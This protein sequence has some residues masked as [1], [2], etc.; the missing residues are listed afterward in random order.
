MSDRSLKLEVIL[1][2]I[3]KATGPIKAV[4]AGSKGLSSAVKEAKDRL[5]ELEQQN[6]RLENFRQV[7]RDVAVTGNAMAAAQGKVKELAQQIRATDQPSKA[8][9]R[10]FEVAKREAAQ[11]KDRHQALTQQQQRLRTELQAA[12]V[13]LQGMARHQA[14]LRRKIDE[15]AGAVN[16]QTEALKRQGEQMRRLQSA[17]EAYDKT[18]DTRNKLAGAGAG[19]AATGAAIGAPIANAVREYSSFEDAMLGVQRQVQGVGEI[20]SASYRQIVAEVKA[21]ARELPVP[22]NQIADMYTAAARMEVPRE[23]LADFTRTVTQMATAFDAVPDE[24]A[25]AMGKVAKNFKI[26]VTEIR[27]LADTINYL[28]DNAIS[29]A[30]DIIDVLN[31]TSGVAASVKISEKAVAALAS[32]LLTLGDTRETAGTAINAIIQRFAAAESGTKDFR[33]AMKSVGLSLKGVQTGMQTDAQGA[34]FQVID[35]IK[36][37]PADQRIGIMVDLVG[38]EHSDTMAKLV[39]NTEEWRRQIEL[40]NDAAASGSMEREFQKRTQAMSAHWQ[41]FKN[42][43]FDINTSTG[44]AL[45][46]RLLGIMDAAGGVLTRIAD[47]MQANPSLTAT[48]VTATAAV[49]A[50]V[51]GMGA[52]T[53]AMAAVLGPFAMA[54]YGIAAFGVFASKAIPFVTMLGKVALP[55]VG[56]A[57]LWIGR[58]L[59]ANPIGLAVTGIALAAGLVYQH[60][61]PIKAWFASIWDNVKQTT[62]Q[63]LE[64]FRGLPAQ[65]AQFGADMM[66][67]LADGIRNAGAAVKDAVTGAAASATGWFKDK[68]GIRSPSRVFAELGGFTMQGLAQGLSKNG[69]DAVDAVLRTARQITLASAGALS[70]SAPAAADTPAAPILPAAEQLMR[71]Q[72]EALPD[73]PALPRLAQGI[74]YQVEQAPAMPELPPALQQIR[75]QLADTPAAPILPAA[76]RLMRYQPEGAMPSLDRDGGVPIDTRQPLAAPG[77]AQAAAPA[78]PA[79]INITINAAPGMDP[80]AIARAVAAEIER[81]QRAQAARGRTRLADLE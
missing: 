22:T 59:M 50:I 18:M 41:R 44:G 81:Q 24:I 31:R 56:Q 27:G 8:M 7:A 29:K 64:F 52:L 43:L 20:G 71:Y 11:L 19:M 16:R 25:E 75:Y 21:L 65:F 6:K 60:W 36:D 48:I 30:G 42:L 74:G 58:A 14:E 62:G 2:A 37:L 17:R 67:G 72:A 79:N 38:M 73:V 78:A 12:G 3:D 13:P 15:A 69:G 63:A 51:T 23:A 26:P 66:R 47:W 45:R 55:A 35:A 32:T 33:A 61:E 34:L 10:N 28:D 1:A 39:S 54:R 80:Q 5:K 40:A 70:L 68:L 77:F 76:E 49:A 4:M 46:E 57:L 53:L 9:L